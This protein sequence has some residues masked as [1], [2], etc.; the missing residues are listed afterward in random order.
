MS[1]TLRVDDLTL[2]LRR[3]ER[4]KTLGITVERDG[5]LVVSAPTAAPQPDIEAFVRQKQFWIYTKLAEKEILRGSGLP[6]REFVNGEGF[7]YL[8]RS[9]RLLL[10]DGDDE[11]PPL[12]LKQSRFH[13]RRDALPR[14]AQHFVDWYRSRGQTWIERRVARW[15]DRLAV[16]PAAVVVRDLGYRWGSCSA[17]GVLYFHWRAACLPPR[18]VDYVLVH[19]LA[20]LHESHH[21]EEYWRRVARAM[22]DYAERKR[23]LAENGRF[24]A[25]EFREGRG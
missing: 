6:P 16:E 18:F 23:W 3:S 9:Y 24:Y 25:L 19:E 7:L 22:P 5:S 20:H 2:A 13:L 14:A 10:V 1:E 15:A 4:R 21:S 8:G 12:Q 11:T 17:D